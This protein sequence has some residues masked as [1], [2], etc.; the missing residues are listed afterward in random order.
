[1]VVST[2]LLFNGIL[3]GVFTVIRFLLPSFTPDV[4]AI[5]RNPQLY[6]RDHYTSILLWSGTLFVASVGLAWIA[7]LPPRWIRK[8][9]AR[10]AMHGPQ[11]WR[12]PLRHW[13]ELEQRNRIIF[14]SAWG[15]AFGSH[16]RDHRVYLGLL[17]KDDTYLYGPLASFNPQLEEN[18]ERDL[19]LSRPIMIRVPT[20]EEPEDYDADALVVSAGE[21]KTASVHRIPIRLLPKARIEMLEDTAGL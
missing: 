8:L 13:S 5:V 10:V 1:M 2:S 11:Q 4:G 12:T 16:E 14:K 21:I 19:V 9:V 15:H 6:F 17:L 18:N 7:A 3:A 20:K